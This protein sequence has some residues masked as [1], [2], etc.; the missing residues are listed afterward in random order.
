MS[1]AF[2]RTLG[3]ACRL[4]WSNAGDSLYRPDGM[5]VPVSIDQCA[6]TVIVCTRDR[7]GQLEACLAG[8]AAQTYTP[9][10]V[11]VVDNASKS[12]VHEI[13]R[14]WGATYVREPVPGLCIARNTGARVAG[15]EIIAYLDDDAVPEAGWLEALLQGFSDPTVAAVSG[16]IR[17]MRAYG[18]PA[19]MSEDVAVE[20]NDPRPRG[21]FDQQT[22]NWFAIACL[23]GVGDGANMAFRKRALQESPGFDERIGR[24]RV[25]EGGDEHV[26]FMSLIALGHRVASSPDAV[27][28]H[29]FPGTRELQQA[30]KKR[31]LR[32]SIAYVIF[33]WV[34]FP[35]GRA[36]ILRHLAR[37][38]L[39][40]LKRRAAASGRADGLKPMQSLRAVLGGPSLYR[41]ARR[42]WADIPAP[43]YRG[44]L[45]AR[46]AQRAGTCGQYDSCSQEKSR[47]S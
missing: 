5:T 38:L 44:L 24:G 46:I 19:T 33:L 37:A 27:V 15:D 40:R 13:C 8:L 39:K 29:P 45:S 43:D 18:D 7:P 31:D 6:A 21:V 17:Y 11:L 12:P 36:D 10:E 22:R 32:I 41:K 2:D 16:Q 1:F 42:E 30:R 25:L 4:G 9:F 26:L 14:R 3:L 23:G 28:A 34:E 20:A 35:W 47:R